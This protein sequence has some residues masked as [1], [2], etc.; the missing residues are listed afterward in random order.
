MRTGHQPRAALA[1]PSTPGDTHLTAE[2]YP[3][4]TAQVQ[5][6]VGDVVPPVTQGSRHG[7]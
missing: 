4:I 5:L 3:H 7:D 1:Q 6:I 2:S